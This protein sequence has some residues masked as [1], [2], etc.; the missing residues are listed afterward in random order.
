MA[1]LPDAI[2]RIEH[3]AHRRGHVYRHRAMVRCGIDDSQ[4]GRHSCRVT[5]RIVCAGGAATT[6][7]IRVTVTYRQPVADFQ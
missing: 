3:H 7:A 2:R 6:G 1:R 4:P 5:V